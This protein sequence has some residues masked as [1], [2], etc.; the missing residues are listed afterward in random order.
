MTHNGGCK[1]NHGVGNLEPLLTRESRILE[2]G[3]ILAV[4]AS[5]RL[6]ALKAAK[7]DCAGNGVILKCR[8]LVGT[9]R[10]RGGVHLQGGYT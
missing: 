8:L 9:S 3:E 5:N 1:S 4:E 10:C 7:A 2:C 6:L